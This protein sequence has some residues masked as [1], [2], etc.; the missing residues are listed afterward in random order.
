M[1]VILLESQWCGK[2]LKVRKNKG[3]IS[4]DPDP[5]TKY[6]H[7]I[8]MYLCFF[9]SQPQQLKS[10]Q[11]THLKADKKEAV[12]NDICY[13]TCKQYIVQI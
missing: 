6:V 2:L 8:C 1:R 5:Q 12:K 3:F 11:K 4:P 10:K 7:V 13:R 9:I